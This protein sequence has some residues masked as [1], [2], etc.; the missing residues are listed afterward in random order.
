MAFENVY[1][2]GLSGVPS[3]FPYTVH[4]STGLN[5]E[6]HITAWEHDS[7]DK[8]RQKITDNNDGSLPLEPYQRLS[9]SVFEAWLR[10]LCDKNPLIELR[11]GV[12]VKS[13]LETETETSVLA[14]DSETGQIRKIVSRFIGACDGASS[15]IRRGLSI[16][17][18][19]GPV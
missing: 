3:H 13:V 19:G 10:K 9:Q 15:R 11:F 8:Y 6:E 2:N 12:A 5:E 14:A 17:L 1:T 18:D 16:P 7:V 4:I